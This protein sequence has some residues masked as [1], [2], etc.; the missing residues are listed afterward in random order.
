MV[1]CVLSEFPPAIVS[2]GFSLESPGLSFFRP[3]LF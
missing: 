1:V 2:L 3:W